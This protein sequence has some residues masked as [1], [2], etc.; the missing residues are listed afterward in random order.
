VY[1]SHAKTRTNIPYTR[2]LS[3]VKKQDHHNGTKQAPILPVE[4]WRVEGSSNTDNRSLKMANQKDGIKD[5]IKDGLS[6]N[7]IF[8]SERKAAGNDVYVSLL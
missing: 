7:Q 1:Y 4:A 5:G 6:A 8:V 2:R 3:K